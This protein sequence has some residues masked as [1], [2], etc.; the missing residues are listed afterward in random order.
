[1]V[2]DKQQNKE[3]LKKKKGKG[4]PFTIDCESTRT[5]FQNPLMCFLIYSW[6]YVVMHIV[7][8][9]CD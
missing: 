7:L 4:R 5:A 2:K 6:H 3:K 9:L 8:D 1:M